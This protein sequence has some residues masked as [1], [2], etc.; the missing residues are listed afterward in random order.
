MP[1]GQLGLACPISMQIEYKSGFEMVVRSARNN[2]HCL[3]V[4]S[5]AKVSIGD[6]GYV[7]EGAFIRMFN[8]TRV[9]R[10]WDDE[11]N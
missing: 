9:T 1:D 6:V 2:S 5:Y 11:S 7:D 3:T 8:V 4:S 10:P